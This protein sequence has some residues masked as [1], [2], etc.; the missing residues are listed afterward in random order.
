MC[1]ANKSTNLT[2]CELEGFA[3]VQPVQIDWDSA[4][5]LASLMIQTLGEAINIFQRKS[6][7]ESVLLNQDH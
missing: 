1:V 3:A 7:D 6:V 2:S 4:H 5:V